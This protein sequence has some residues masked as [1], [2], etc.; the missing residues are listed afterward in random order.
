MVDHFCVYNIVNILILADSWGLNVASESLQRF[1]QW[2]ESSAY[3]AYN[4]GKLKRR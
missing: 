4:R 2:Y 1:N 3:H